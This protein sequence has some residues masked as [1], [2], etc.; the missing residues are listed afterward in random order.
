MHVSWTGNRC[1]FCLKETSLSKEHLIPKALGGT[2]TCTFLCT[3]CNSTLGSSFEAAARADPSIR[4]AVHNLQAQMPELAKKLSE[5]QPVLVRGPGG[6]ERGKIR[7]GEL[8]VRPRSA[9]DGSLIQP[10]GRARKSVETIL[11]KSGVG[12]IPLAEAL[13]KFDDTPDNHKATVVL[14]LEVVKWSIEK[15]DLDLSNSSLMSPLV[16][17]KIGFEFLACHLGTAIYDEAQQVQE[18]R[19]ALCEMLEYNPSYEVE[20]LNTSEYKPFHGICFEGNDPYARVLIRLFGWLAFRVH[21]RRLS[22]S[23]PRYV[24]TQSLDTEAED[25]RV[26][27]P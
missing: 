26:L 12:A 22:I 24:Y 13:R 18:L 7:K 4:I 11:R 8:R 27:E 14:G 9:E 15:I 1:L 6:K 25:L 2:L 10:T 5:D 19:T 21:F 16:P 3:H 17:L 23:G 20:R